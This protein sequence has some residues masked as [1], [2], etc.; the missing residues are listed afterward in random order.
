MKKI[1]IIG[2]GGSGKSTFSHKLGEL[3]QLPVY[4]LDALYWKPGWIP[5]PKDEWDTF[6]KELILK[7]EWIID[8]NYGRTLEIRM[9][10]ADTII[11]FDLSRWVTTYRIIKRRIMYHGKTR[12][13]LTEGCPERLDF[14]FIKWVWNFRRDSRPGIMDKLNKYAQSKKIIMLRTTA[15]V[16][17]LLDHISKNKE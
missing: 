4:H 6:Q 2:S 17:S 14:K 13:D 8:G 1:V 15:E 12:P 3:T 11:F 7:N 5:T 16:N 9:S 10:E